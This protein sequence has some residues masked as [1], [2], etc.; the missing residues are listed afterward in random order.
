MH[1]GSINKGSF[2]SDMVIQDRL[3]IS[4][5]SQICPKRGEKKCKLI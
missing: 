3:I 5:E 4:T 2:L 1:S